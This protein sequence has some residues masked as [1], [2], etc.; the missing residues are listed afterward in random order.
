[1]YGLLRYL[2]ILAQCLLIVKDEMKIFYPGIIYSGMGKIIPE[3]FS[4]PG[5][6]ISLDDPVGF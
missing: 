4:S 5:K 3:D 1:M 2:H 6:Y